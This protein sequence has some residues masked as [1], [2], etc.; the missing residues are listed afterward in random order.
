MELQ[1]NDNNMT[2]AAVVDAL[3]DHIGCVQADEGG[4]HVGT[5]LQP[6]IDAQAGGN[7]ADEEGEKQQQEEKVEKVVVA[8]AATNP[9]EHRGIIQRVSKAMAAPSHSRRRSFSQIA[10]AA[11]EKKT[12]Q[13][14]EVGSN[15]KEPTASA[16][17]AASVS[18][19]T[20]AADCPCGA[21]KV[22][23]EVTETR[24][25]TVPRYYINCKGCNKRV[26]CGQM[27]CPPCGHLLCQTC[28]MVVVYERKG[29]PTCGGTFREEDCPDNPQFELM[30]PIFLVKP[31]E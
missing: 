8:E 3:D 1:K 14:G 4:V 11:E 20:D 23:V 10:D 2:A 24:E 19:T 16:A 7:K 29:C 18:A 26:G 25:V 17:A 22:R 12:D 13:V 21:K 9:L 15:S 28:C 6:E 31:E 5:L 27:V 30:R